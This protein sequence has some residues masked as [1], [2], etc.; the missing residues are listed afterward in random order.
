[1]IESSN[2]YLNPFNCLLI[3]SFNWFQIGRVNALERG[4]VITYYKYSSHEK[5]LKLMCYREE[6]KKK[7]RLFELSIIWTIHSSISTNN[8]ESTVQYIEYN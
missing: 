5:L 1:M 8:R 2:D 3:V 7:N 6:R 4:L